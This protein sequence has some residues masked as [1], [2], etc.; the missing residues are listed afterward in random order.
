MSDLDNGI[1]SVSVDDN[2]HRVWW[3]TPVHLPEISNECDGIS[4]CTLNMITIT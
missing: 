1:T 3:V 4:K 2:F